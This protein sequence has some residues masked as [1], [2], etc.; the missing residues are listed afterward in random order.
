[1]VRAAPPGAAAGEAPVLRL[2]SARAREQL[3]W[4]PRWDLPQA[5]DATVDWH[6][7][8]R[9][10]ADMRDG[11]PAPDRGLL[12]RRYGVRVSIGIVGLGYVGL[13][14]AIAFAEAGEEV[15]GVDVDPGK[16]QGLRSGVS[17]IEDIPS[18]QLAAVMDRMEFTT[19][20]VDLHGAEAILICVP[21][22]LNR[23]REP[24]LGPLLG[25]ARTLAGVIAKGQLVVLESTTFPGTTRDHLVPLLEESGLVAGRDFSLAFSPER[26]DPGRTDYTIANTPKIVGGLTPDCTARALDV[27]GRVCGTLVPV[28]TPEVAEMAKLLENIFRSVNIALVNELAMLAD[29]M[30]IDIWEVVDAAS[31]KPFGFMRFEPGPGMGGHCL[32]VDPFYLTWKAREYDMVTEFI[33]LAGKVNKQ[34]PYFCLEKIERALNEAGKPVKGSRML[35]V[36]VAYKGGVGD[37][38]ESP[39]LKIIE[40]LQERGGDVRY[41]DPHVAE[42]PAHGLRSVE[43][44]GAQ[45]DLAVIVT[46]HPGVDHGLLVDAVAG[47]ARPAR[48]H[49]LARRRHRHSAVDVAQRGR[50]HRRRGALAGDRQR[51]GARVL[52][53]P[54]RADPRGHRGDVP[55]RVQPG[56]GD[57]LGEPA[58]A[59]GDDG[60]P[61]RHR[62]QR[63]EREDL[64]VARGDERDRGAGAQRGELAR[65]DAA[66]EADVRPGRGAQRLRV[67]PVAG[68]D[69]RH[70][71]PRGS[72]RSRPRRPSRPRAAPRRARSRPRRPRSARRTCA[73]RSGSRGRGRRAARRGRGGGPARTRSGRRRR[74]PRPRSA[75]ATAR[76]RRRTRPPPRAS[77][78]GSSAGRRAACCARGSACSPPR[79]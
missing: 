54:Q 58:G 10:G 23:N 79:A 46:A 1:M 6:V 42:L 50:D 56:G 43:L 19:R 36:G 55:R 73:G 29:R 12:R 31:S 28:S 64:R 5:L 57:D 14:L 77:R 33:E 41:H 45:C 40:L 3:G 75:P 74:R 15:I 68:D 59:R 39:A 16:I 32:P 25:A 52:V 51:G 63:G 30:K 4:A 70:A 62:L 18:E 9:E 61:G 35:I 66:H 11:D 13:P 76:G 7:R 17:H 65:A 8:R 26:V 24:D 67:G 47:R 21:T 37:L 2:D 38:R 60:E 49:A 22:P 34:M 20:A 48:R 53:A 44:A 78:R 69:E 72:R 71:R 27:Y